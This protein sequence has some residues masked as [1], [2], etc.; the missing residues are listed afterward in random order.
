MSVKAGQAQSWLKSNYS[1]LLLLL[2]LL[3]LIGSSMYLFVNVDGISET[4]A[5]HGRLHYEVQP[6]QK[7]SSIDIDAY[8]NALKA[9]QSPYQSTQQVKRMMVSELRVGMCALREADSF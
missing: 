5:K 1:K 3:F 8:D 7:V 4:L 9:L 6:D 2:A